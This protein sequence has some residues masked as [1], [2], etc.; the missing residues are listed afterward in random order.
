MLRKTVV[1]DGKEV[2]FKASAAVPRIYRMKFRRDL[3]VDLQKV[4]KS[5]DKKGKK[6]GKE[7]K[8]E[9][10]ESEI[11]IENLEMFENIAY[12]MAQHADPQNVPADIMEWMEQFETFS[13]YQI[14]P[15]IL[16]LW[17]MNEETKSNAKKNLDQVAGS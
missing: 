9:K 4:A 1:I 15:A 17:N 2:E 11:P 6:E 14:L 8:E 10:E 7:E 3:F 5:V 13:I 16:E 12:V